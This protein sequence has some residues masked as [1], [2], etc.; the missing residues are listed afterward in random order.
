MLFVETLV[1][2]LLASIALAWAARR[3]AVPYPI[4][5][6]T[7]G[8]ALGF[9]T[10]LPRF[11]LDPD[12]ILVIVLPPILYQAALFTSWRDFKENLRAIS[13]LAVG[14]VVAT[15]LIA[16]GVLKWLLPEIPW[17]VAFAFGAIVSPPDA[18]AA[19]AVLSRVQVPRR[20]V[21]IVEGE[22]LVNDASG[23]VLYKFAVAAAMAG[24]FSVMKASGEF[25]LVAAGGLL[26]GWLLGRLFV[27]V[28]TR[29]EDPLIEIMLAI[30]LPYSAYL[31]AEALHVSGVLAV[32]TAGLVRA[33]HA[34]EVFSAQSRIL[35]YSVWKV[36]VFLLNC[37]VFILIGLQLAEIVEGITSYSLQQLLG[38]AVLLALVLVVVRFAWV[39]PGAYLP[40]VIGRA[41][42]YC[43]GVPPWQQVAI[44]GWCGMRGIVS[45][46]A[47]LALPLTLPDG[48]PFP[49]RN[50]LI[51][52]TFAAI[53]LTLVLPG[54]T[55]APIIQRLRLGSDGQTAEEERV[56]REATARAALDE[57]AQ[58]ASRREISKTDER[59]LRREYEE[60][61]A[62]TGPLTIVHI[63]NNPLAK[64]RQA[65]LAAERRRLIELWREGKIGD[66]TL[67][68]IERELDLEETRLK[69]EGL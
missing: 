51:F 67:H 46:A 19:T 38:Y 56:A 29:L 17:P 65:L 32:V 39:Y 43:E 5:L 30:A 48:S 21:T 14:L 47:A 53:F 22:S 63:T 58:L 31:A 59:H 36:I 16:G 41:F 33:R 28:H 49:G 68:R 35:A 8:A 1:I 42:G 20:I 37:L 55:L 18:V 2:L 34:P 12:L 52:L 26:F 50:V 60:R 15:T 57:F 10:R 11:T 62:P 45:L 6:V 3:L 64:V 4:A 61:L 7:G 27:A 13:L 66:E 54:L 69:N 23:L 25:V 40:P 9:V 44:V 24:S